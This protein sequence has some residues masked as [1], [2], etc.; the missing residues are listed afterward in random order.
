LPP[1]YSQG[2]LI[3]KSVFK[4][5][6]QYYT[7]TWARLQKNIVTV[8]LPECGGFKIIKIQALK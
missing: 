1:S 4:V 3:N 8:E 6:I 7:S 2:G 5:E